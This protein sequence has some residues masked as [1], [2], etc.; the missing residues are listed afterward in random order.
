MHR[1]LR[2]PDPDP[3]SLSLS[4]FQEPAVMGTRNG[5]Q[6][7]IGLDVVD[8]SC[9]LVADFV[10]APKQSLTLHLTG[11]HGTSA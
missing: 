8:V 4:F 6:G 9:G 11:D 7:V 1:V 2:M 3:A 5:A 10:F